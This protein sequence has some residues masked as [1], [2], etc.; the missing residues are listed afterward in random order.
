MNDK[1]ATNT[2]LALIS[3]FNNEME[4]PEEANALFSCRKK[5]T[6]EALFV[7]VEKKRWQRWLAMDSRNSLIKNLIYGNQTD[8]CS[9]AFSQIELN[10]I[11]IS[12]YLGF[13]FVADWIFLPIGGFTVLIDRGFVFFAR[14]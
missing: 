6:L 12:N 2:Q 14:S 5:A 13:D 4:S 11:F 7:A 1:S 3:F 10:E 9:A 8:G